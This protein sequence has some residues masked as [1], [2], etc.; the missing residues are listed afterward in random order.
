MDISWNRLKAI[1][2]LVWNQYL[3]HVYLSG[4]M[5]GQRE[6]S[7][8]TSK[9]LESQEV[10]QFPQGRTALLP[11]NPVVWIHEGAELLG[12]SCSPS[13]R[14]LRLDR[15]SGVQDEPELHWLCLKN[16]RNPK[17]QTKMKER[18]IYKRLRTP[19][20]TSNSSLQFSTSTLEPPTGN[21]LEDWNSKDFPLQPLYLRGGFR[22]LFWNQ[23]SNYNFQVPCSRTHF[24]HTDHC[25]KIS[26]GCLCA[27]FWWEDGHSDSLGKIPTALP[28]L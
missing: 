20:S 24:Y 19:W 17:L 6:T 25:D 9:E 7:Y 14:K 11:V 13:S 18:K 27:P 8:K 12:H 26:G 21:I 2:C 4:R 1:I 23:F 22:N 5:G 3:K 28:A 15:W 10:K 16:K